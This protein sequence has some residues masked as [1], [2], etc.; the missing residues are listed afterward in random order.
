MSNTANTPI[1]AVLLKKYHNITEFISKDESRF[2]LNGAHYNAEKKRLEATDGAMLICVPVE[3][4]HHYP[5]EDNVS[6]PKS[7]VIPRGIFARAMRSIPKTIIDILNSVRLTG[8]DN[9][10]A[11]FSTI[12]ADDT[13]SLQSFKTIDG[14]Y[15]NLDLPFDQAKNA[16]HKFTIKL[17]ADKLKKLV[18]YAY[19]CG[20][21]QNL[22]I[23][24]FKFQDALSGVL[25]EVPVE[26]G[27]KAEGVL[28]P[29]KVV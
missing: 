2:V 16:E 18:D 28:M 8:G 25:F 5:G 24:T 15:P 6:E 20:Q 14:N 26:M 13:R 10:K 29:A 19:K 12:D 7:C 4:S 9:L 23:I 22:T 27:V 1:P 11:S 17:R 3:V 21:E